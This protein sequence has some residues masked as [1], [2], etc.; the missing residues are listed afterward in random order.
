MRTLRF[1]TLETD[2]MTTNNHN[3]RPLKKRKFGDGE[4]VSATVAPIEGATLAVVAN[5]KN[6]GRRYWSIKTKNQWQKYDFA[7]FEWVDNPDDD[8]R[9]AQQEAFAQ[10]T[11]MLEQ[12]AKIKVMVESLTEAVT[13]MLANQD[14]LV[15]EIKAVKAKK[16]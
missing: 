3:E 10:T 1:T 5:G 4:P 7:F 8:F 14:A 16:Q 11:Q 2:A 13:H 15:A 9:E 6:A 12:S